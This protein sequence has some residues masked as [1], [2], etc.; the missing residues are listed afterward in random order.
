MLVL[1]NLPRPH[2][3][4]QKTPVR[5]KGRILRRQPR[6]CKWKIQGTLEFG[7]ANAGWKRLFS[8]RRWSQ[9]LPK[10]PSRCPAISAPAFSRTSSR[11][12]S[13]LAGLFPVETLF[14]LGRPQNCAHHPRAATL[15]FS[16][17]PQSLL[18]PYFG[19]RRL[20]KNWNQNRNMGVP[21]VMGGSRLDCLVKAVGTTAGRHSQDG[22]V[23]VFEQAPNGP[24]A[25]FARGHRH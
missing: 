1:V 12:S 4:E 6:N 20:L 14:S 25:I 21:S 13:G 16:L 5:G 24:A 17:L 8:A 2:F 10:R 22:C 15:F 3:S 23:P 11:S 19:P 9:G 18:P 7:R